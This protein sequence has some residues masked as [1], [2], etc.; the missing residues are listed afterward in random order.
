[1]P[2][3]EDPVLEKLE[4]ILSLIRVL[5][6]KILFVQQDIEDLKNDQ[7]EKIKCCVEQLA[8]KQLDS[9]QDQ[10]SSKWVVERL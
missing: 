9:V 10:S 1:M 8:Q 7:L 4:E 3:Y 5:D 2:M 6:T